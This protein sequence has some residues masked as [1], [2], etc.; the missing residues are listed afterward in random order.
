M[1]P[2]S[3]F[4]INTLEIS[5]PLGYSLLSIIVVI[6]GYLIVIT[7][8][9]NLKSDLNLGITIVLFAL[10]TNRYLVDWRSGT[11][12]DQL[13]VLSFIT[14][15]TLLIIFSKA[16]LAKKVFSDSIKQEFY[17]YKK[18]KLIDVV[19][20]LLGFMLF[21]LISTE[22]LSL[23]ILSVLLIVYIVQY[24]LDLLSHNGKS[25][26]LKSLILNLALSSISFLLISWQP[27]YS[28][29]NRNWW[30]FLLLG[31]FIVLLY[32]QEFTKRLSLPKPTD[33]E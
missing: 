3:I 9:E 25:I 7:I 8:F 10:L 20:L 1:D 23:D 31:I 6:L 18:Y 2:I 12:R 5:L 19:F 11:L 24:F 14:S 15:L 26:M 33:L 4:F 21:K 27:I 29:L 16:F 22:S 32:D 30:I 28:L 13:L 17:T